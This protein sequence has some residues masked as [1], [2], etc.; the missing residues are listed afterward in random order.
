[1]AAFLLRALE[2]FTP[3][4]PSSQRFTDVPSSNTF[5]SFIDRM[6][7]VGI[8][9]GCNPDHT[10]YCPGANV[11]RAQMAAFLVRAFRL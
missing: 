4:P 3:P 10:L 11:T 8:T 6:G 7:V 5:Y 1:M 2:E 9:L